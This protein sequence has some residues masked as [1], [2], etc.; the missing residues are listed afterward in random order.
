MILITARNSQ[1]KQELAESLSGRV[2]ALAAAN[3]LV[4]RTFSDVAFEEQVSIADVIAVVL[5]PYREPQ[6]SGPKVTLGER[7]VNNIALVFHELATNASK[8]GSLTKDD[9]VVAVDWTMRDGT[10]ALEWREIGGPPVAVPERKGFGSSLVERT[11]AD[12]GGKIAYE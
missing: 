1:T 2:R 8:Y 3:A 11:V 12:R 4:R 7:A 5:W 6:L 10:I 9:G